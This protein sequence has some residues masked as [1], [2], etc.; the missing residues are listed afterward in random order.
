VK[1]AEALCPDIA[2]LDMNMPEHDGLSVLR[3]VRRAELPTAVIFLT[4]HNDESTF[5]L[6]LDAGAKGYVLKESAITE[7]VDCIKAVHAGR[8]YI[9]PSLTT[10][11]VNRSRPATSTSGE[12]SI[13][14][15]TATERRVLKLVAVYKTSQEIADE[16]CISIRTVNNHRTH[17]AEKLKLQG[18]HALLKFAAEHAGEL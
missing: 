13:Q 18:S 11:L 5:N 15:L 17:I 9:S 12:P 1:S 16:L 14:Q 3:E 10:H 4:M 6:A 8:H 7:I 2:I